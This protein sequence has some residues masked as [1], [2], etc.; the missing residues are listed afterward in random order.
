MT[1]PFV[2]WNPIEWVQPTQVGLGSWS[3]AIQCVTW[4]EWLFFHR[5]QGK[6]SDIPMKPKQWPSA[7]IP[8]T[9]SQVWGIQGLEALVRPES[10]FQWAEWRGNRIIAKAVFSHFFFYCNSKTFSSE[11]PFN[12]HTHSTTC[13]F[14]LCPKLSTSPHLHCFCFG[15]GHHHLSPGLSE[16]PPV[17]SPC[18]ILPHPQLRPYHPLQSFPNSAVRR[19]LLKAKV[20]LHHSLAPNPLMAQ[21]RGNSKS[22][23]GLTRSPATSVL[24]SS[25]CLFS[26]CSSHIG[27]LTPYTCQGLP[28]S[29]SK[30]PFLLFAGCFWKGRREREG[31]PA[32]FS[33]AKGRVKS[34]QYR[35]LHAHL[36]PVHRMCKRTSACSLQLH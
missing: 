33:G 26:P 4:G 28:I 8:S 1:C 16:Q 6:R 21:L 22:S 12:T 2:T 29:S 17:W 11:P 32:L 5:P 34:L 20:R 15:P 30:D 13:T 35:A 19:S 31:S 18:C 25:S 9:H 3:P 14:K 24:T 7:H 23:Q 36:C 27:P 10:A